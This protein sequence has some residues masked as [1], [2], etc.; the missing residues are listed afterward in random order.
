MP[1]PDPVSERDSLVN[2]H[3]G[4]ACKFAL[5][6]QNRGLPLE[7]L[8]QEALLGLLEAAQ[9]FEPER[10]WNFS[11]YACH[12]IKKRLRSALARENPAGWKT[13]PLGERDVAAP[14][15]QNPDLA[16]SEISFPLSMPAAERRVLLLSINQGLPLKE[17]A[18]RLGISVERVKQLRSKALRRIKQ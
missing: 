8:R 11:T 7:D 14:D 18:A 17:V 12:W 9:R 15:S 13:E 10:G 4:L 6:C 5:D 3:I 2:R 16:S 1:A